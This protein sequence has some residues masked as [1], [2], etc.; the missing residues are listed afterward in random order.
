[1]KKLLAIGG[2][3]IVIFVLIIV[4]TNKSNEVKLKDSPY[5]KENLEAST[6][7]LIDNEN[8]QNIIMPDE[9]EKKIASG[10]PV[11]AY[12]FSPLC[13]YCMEMTPVLMPI[14]DEMGVEVFQ[15]NVL[16]YPE[17]AAI[18]NIEATPSL[19]YFEDGE[20]VVITEDGKEVDRS[21]RVGA[22]P[23]NYIREFFEKFA[24]KEDGTK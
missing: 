2:V 10:E 13:S 7:D 9:L 3:V 8:Y 18:Y 11:T 14:A 6:I 4:L 12:F 1:M 21:R 19:I 23:E 15:Y 24:L 22:Q 17:E 20:E 5:D 16:E